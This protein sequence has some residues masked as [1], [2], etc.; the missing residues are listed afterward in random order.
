MKIPSKATHSSSKTNL[1]SEVEGWNPEE[2]Q[3]HERRVDGTRVL[4]TRGAVM[5]AKLVA[6]RRRQTGRGSTDERRPEKY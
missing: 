2:W 4:M 3:L 1:L 5:A 6:R